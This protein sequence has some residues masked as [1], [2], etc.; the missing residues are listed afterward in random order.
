MGVRPRF[1]RSSFAEGSGHHTR[2]RVQLCFGPPTI[3][4]TTCQPTDTPVRFSPPPARIWSL[5]PAGGGRQPADRP[6]SSALALPRP[7]AARNWSNA[8]AGPWADFPTGSYV[9]QTLQRWPYKVP[10]RTAG[11]GRA[12]AGGTG[13]Q[14]RAGARATGCPPSGQHPTLRLARSTSG[15]PNS[16]P[17]L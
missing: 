1:A 13:R 5:A 10:G 9:G 16:R 11:P 17:D 8:P 3:A 4:V 14:R 15:S 2:L 12:R 6:V 7:T